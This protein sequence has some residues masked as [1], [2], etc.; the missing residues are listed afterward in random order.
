[1]LIMDINLE[2]W[3]CL[4]H[5][6]SSLSTH[7]QVL[8]FPPPNC[9]WM[10][11]VPLTI[12]ICLSMVLLHILPGKGWEPPKRSISPI[13]DS[14]SLFS[15]VVFFLVYTDMILMIVSSWDSSTHLR[16]CFPITEAGIAD[17]WIL[18]VSFQHCLCDNH[19][20]WPNMPIPCIC[21]SLHPGLFLHCLPWNNVDFNVVMVCIC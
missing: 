9:M 14:A 3:T 11:C 4:S 5:F 13:L 20:I 2:F 10:P 15:I 1:M 19:S 7:Q 18:T 6:L 21:C 12:T 17:H 8:P 16:N